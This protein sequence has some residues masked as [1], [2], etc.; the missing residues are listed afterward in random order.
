MWKMSGGSL[1]NCIC[2]ERWP[3][4]LD[5]TGRWSMKMIRSGF[6]SMI[7]FFSFSIDECFEAN[8]DFI[9]S[10]GTLNHSIWWF[11]NWRYNSCKFG[12][13]TLQLP[14]LDSSWLLISNSFIHVPY[15]SDI[16]YL[17][18][19]LDNS[20]LFL[21][22]T[23]GASINTANSLPFESDINC[24]LLNRTTQPQEIICPNIAHL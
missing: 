16:H 1:L 7:L 3:N 22:R 11:V 23:W 4:T 5:G 24:H 14:Q 8:S 15:S 13:M 19:V 18:E 6:H 10:C 20:I 17:N 12:E 2:N 21:L 9:I